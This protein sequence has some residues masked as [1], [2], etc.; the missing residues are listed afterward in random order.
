[1]KKD[2]CV[3]TQDITKTTSRRKKP[4]HAYT[5]KSIIKNFQTKK[6]SGL[7]GFIGEFY[8]IIVKRTLEVVQ[9]GSVGRSELTSSHRHKKSTATYKIT[10]EKRSKN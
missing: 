4:Q 2:K 5:G 3:K 9:D 10:P 1:M 6:S 8:Q 7:D